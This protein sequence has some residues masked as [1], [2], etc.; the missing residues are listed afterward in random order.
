MKFYP[1]T[2][3]TDRVEGLRPA[4]V[5]LDALVEAL[6]TPPQKKAPRK[7]EKAR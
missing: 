6:R 4:A 3:K 7:L 5:S 1:L 2:E